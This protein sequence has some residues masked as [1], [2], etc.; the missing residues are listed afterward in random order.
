M[1][2]SARA[3]TGPD[4]KPPDRQQDALAHLVAI[5]MDEFGKPVSLFTINRWVTDETWYAADDVIAMLDRF[6]VDLARPSWPINRW[7]TAMVD[8]FR[9]QIEALIVDRD[10]V[11]SR[12][13]DQ[14]GE[15]V[16]DDHALEVTA[17]RPIDIDR[18]LDAIAEALAKA[19]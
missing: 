2:R 6:V 12:R 9:P 5:S 3:I 18:Q 14:T 8:L 16:F 17:V 4:G 19:T 10:A 7:I 13:A 1:P 15:E 11:V